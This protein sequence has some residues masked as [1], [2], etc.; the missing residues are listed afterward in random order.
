[1]H[2]LRLSL[3]LILVLLTFCGNSEDRKFRVLQFKNF[4]LAE[5][6]PE[7]PRELPSMFHYIGAD[8]VQAGVYSSNDFFHPPEGVVIMETID[9]TQR[10]AAYYSKVI[11]RSGWNIIQST[12]RDEEIL[13]MCESPT[14][15]YR[16]LVTIIM[17]GRGPSLI[18]IYFRRSEG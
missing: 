9:D 18:K 1:M 17:R 14:A 15:R 16:K 2:P 13:L 4:S 3:I 11:R 6:M 10:I 5:N 7:P 12:H 8:V